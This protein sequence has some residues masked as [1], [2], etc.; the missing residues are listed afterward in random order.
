[1]ASKVHGLEQVL[2]N[3]NERI[4]AIEGA[5]MA[6]LYE[7]GLK[8][9]AVSQKRTPVDQG[10]LKGS[11]Y[12]RGGG[13]GVTRLEEP[14]DSTVA[15]MPTGSVKPTTVEIGYTANYALYVHEDMQARH[16][17]G[18]AKYLESSLRDNEDEIV[19]IVQQKA[20]VK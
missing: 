2:S 16:K 3:L 17:V 7:A 9:Q 15:P 5:S 11:A 14:D 4:E 13:Q 12:T 8:I 20:E 18:Q 1:M 19:D 6:G 10:N